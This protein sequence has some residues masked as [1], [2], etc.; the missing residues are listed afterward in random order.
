MN[1][2]SKIC[3][4]ASVCCSPFEMSK[5]THLGTKGVHCSVGVVS[6]HLVLT[7]SEISGKTWQVSA[8]SV[9]GKNVSAL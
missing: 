7:F 8:I 3:L 2:H 4:Y 5:K 1:L 9:G 6:M